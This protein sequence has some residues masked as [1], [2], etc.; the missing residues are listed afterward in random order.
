[1]VKKNPES[2]FKKLIL[3][4]WVWVI[5]A[6]VSYLI[7]VSIPITWNESGFG[8]DT[9]EGFNFIKTLFAYVTQIAWI[10]AVSLLILSGIKYIQKTKINDYWKI[11][12]T[13]LGIVLI[14]AYAIYSISSFGIFH[15]SSS[16]DYTFNKDDSAKEFLTEQGYEVL[17]LNFGSYSTEMAI[18]NRFT[19]DTNCYPY[20]GSLSSLESINDTCWS[21]FTQ[22]YVEMKSLG[23]RNSQIWDG[24][25]T[26][27]GYDGVSLYRI[28]I[29]SHTETCTYYITGRTYN[30][31]L[32]VDIIDNYSE[33][34]LQLGREMAQ[35]VNE[36]IE[37]YKTCS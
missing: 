19:T 35:K 21:N 3:T 37:K 9:F 4:W 14:I 26:F 33:E 31:Y 20:R 18:K 29:L 1:M 17:S 27:A 22:A 28:D 7:F 6:I 13:I 30:D 24:L 25:T 8:W 32:N 34:N 10:V 23:N 12:L 2:K 5:I 36:E 15:K 16:E 11:S